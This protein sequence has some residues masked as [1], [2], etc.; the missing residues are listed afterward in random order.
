[1]EQSD[2]VLTFWHNLNNY[3]ITIIINNIIGT[4]IFLEYFLSRSQW[5]E[6][7]ALNVHTKEGGGS[8]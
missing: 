2:L 4:F 8:I 7:I 6:I 3:T 1:M 5:I